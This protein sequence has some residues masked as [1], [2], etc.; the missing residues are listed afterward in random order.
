MLTCLRYFDGF[1]S[2]VTPQPTVVATSPE[3]VLAESGGRQIGL[4]ILRPPNIVKLF[5]SNL[6]CA[7]CLWRWKYLAT[8]EAE[9]TYLPMKGIFLWKVSTYERHLPMKGIYLWKVSTYERYLPMRSRVFW[10]E[11][12]ISYRNHL[13]WSP[14]IADRLKKRCIRPSLVDFQFILER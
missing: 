3:N 13:A 12:K 8:F 4:A 10:S 7:I 5:C 2:S 9:N 11:E 1:P 14:K 6:H